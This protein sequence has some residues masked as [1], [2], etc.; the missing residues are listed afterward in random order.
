MAQPIKKPVHQ[1][2][3]LNTLPSVTLPDAIYY[4][5]DSATQKIKAYITDNIGV[6]TLLFNAGSSQNTT[7][8]KR[9]EFQYTGGSQ[10]F[11]LIDNYYQVFSVD[12]QGQGALSLSQYNLISP[13]KVEILDILNIN[14]YVVILYGKDLL[15]PD[16]PYYTQA[17][18]DSLIG[19]ISTQNS[20]VSNETPSGVLNGVNTN[21][22]SLY[23]FIPETVE[24]FLNGIFQKRV[25]DYQTVGTNTI[26]MT[27]SPLSTETILI[28]YIKL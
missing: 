4:V 18:I 5:L 28:N 19:S 26:V 17:E 21:Y 27:T 13:N 1:Y 25:E 2:K 22:T 9:Q 8:I 15:T 11:T 20:R 14:D 7:S 12:V 24:V 16:A 6:P 3:E 10:I 23:S